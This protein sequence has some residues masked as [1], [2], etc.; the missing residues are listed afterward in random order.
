MEFQKFPFPSQKSADDLFQSSLKTLNSWTNNKNDKT[1][2][3]TTNDSWTVQANPGR[4]ATLLNHDRLQL[5]SGHGAKAN[6]DEISSLIPDLQDPNI[7][8]N[9]TIC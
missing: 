3:D 2:L 7:N 5:I 4:L 6:G 1:A 8:C 9:I